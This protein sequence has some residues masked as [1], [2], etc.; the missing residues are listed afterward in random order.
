VNPVPTETLPS[1]VLMTAAR[2]EAWVIDLTLRSVVT[3]TVRPLRWLIVSDGSTDGTDT[4][5]ER[6]AREHSWIELLRLETGPGRDF[7]R[8]ARALN[9]AHERL[10]RV[11]HDIIGVL[12]ADISVEEDHFA[13]LLEKFVQRPDLG[14]AGTPYIEEG[15]HYDYRFT[16]PSHVSGCCQLFKR[17]C[18]EQIGDLVAVEAGGE[19]WIAVTTARMNGWRTQTFV[20]K[21]AVHHRRA[22]SGSGH[23]V[24]AIWFRRGQRDYALG[25]DPV[26][27]LARSLYQ[28][29]FRPYLFGG[30]TLLAGYL[31]EVVRRP[32]RP[33]SAE[34][35]RFHRAEQRRRLKRAALRLLTLRLPRDDAGDTSGSSLGD[36]IRRLQRWV[37][38]HDYRGYEPFDGLSSNIR[39]LTFGNRT[40]EQALLQ[41]G[42]QSPFNLRPWLGIKPADSTK[43]R[44]YMASG[45][46]A[47]LEETGLDE[48]RSK[49]IEC[50]E[51][52][53]RNRSPLYAEHSWGNHFDYASRAGRIAKHESTIVWTSLIGQVFLDAYEVL[54]EPRYLDVASSVCDW[55]RQL[56]RETTPRGTC[57][58]YLAA[59]QLSIH[60]SNL[61]GAAMLARTAKH[62]GA[63]ELV[64]VAR[65]AVEYSCSRQ[66]PDGAWYYGEQ[67]TYHWIDCFHTGY[68]LDSLKCY[69]DSTGDQVFRTQLELGLRYF[70]KTFVEPAG[71]PRYYHNRAYPID[72]QC[73]AQAIET[74]SKF[75]DG[76][77]AM[78]RRAL[79]VADWT[80]SHM[81]D[82][83]GFFYYRQYPLFDVKI[84]MLHWGQATMYRALSLL[85]LKVVRAAGHLETTRELM[86]SS[87][88]L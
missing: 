13:F 2:N 88:T 82:P 9:S 37:E 7:A 78:L 73:A 58:S 84:P 51:W 41:I 27:E 48:Y 24:G 50:L 80:M 86:S 54:R 71:R 23:S 53:I 38:T 87:P 44:G 72:I 85:S 76:D 46:L 5:I 66:L 35:I 57:L 61:L 18:F 59:R 52:L 65:A 36:G 79:R 70:E 68:N 69:I 67:A 22:G 17:E 14:V 64:D 81:Q 30:A 33:V 77:P 45:Y 75:S 20:E 12:D 40:L 1:Y 56:P 39:R 34:L 83:S 15:L 28:S 74:L 47:R 49:A 29:T 63:A 10:R 21:V 8:K 60:N 4:I 6:Y 3:Q 43:G 31:Y 32:P 19:D 26:W 25:F 16:S 11:R 55:I 62:T 42:R